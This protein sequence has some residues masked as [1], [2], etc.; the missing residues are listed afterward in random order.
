[1]MSSIR[2]LLADGRKQ[3]EAISDTAALDAEVLMAHVLGQPRAWVLAHDQEEPSLQRA[4]EWKAGISKL[5][6]GLP[7]PYYLG[8]WEFYGRSFQVTPDVLIPRPETE[9]MIEQA[10]AWLAANPD[11]RR[12]ADVGTGSGVIADTLAAEVGDLEVIA[13]DLSPEALAVAQTNAERHSV[14]DRVRFAQGNLLS[15]VTTPLDLICANLPYVPSER[16]PSLRVSKQEPMLA[17]DGGDGDGFGLV[18]KLAAQ[19]KSLLAPGG[20][21]L[22]EIDSSQQA[23][24]EELGRQTWPNAKVTV[25]DDL[26][27]RPRLL[28]VQ[29]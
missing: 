10:L 23:I 20:L 24:A 11:R 5:A 9:L 17:L 15:G 14:A 13:I 27:E 3:L 1:M 22:A 26:T 2:E 6:A 21:L 29:A 12:A 4:V 28:R 7:L 18:R 25:L 19:A 16:L 8:E